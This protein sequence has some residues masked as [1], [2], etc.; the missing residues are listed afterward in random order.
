M[1]NLDRPYVISLPAGPCPRPAPSASKLRLSSQAALFPYLHLHSSAPSGLAPG[2]SLNPASS[3]PLLCHLPL[4][5]RELHR[6]PEQCPAP[7]LQG[8]QV[9]RRTPLYLAMAVFLCTYFSQGCRAA[10]IHPPNSN[11]T[12]NFICSMNAVFIYRFSV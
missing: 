11:Q 4:P 10:Q 7:S 2:D 12:Q 6:G 8:S 3:L 9:P 5:L 1:G